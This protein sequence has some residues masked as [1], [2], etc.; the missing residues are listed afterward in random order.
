MSPNTD[1]PGDASDA[2]DYALPLDAAQPWGSCPATFEDAGWRAQISCG[3]SGGGG[4]GGTAPGTGGPPLDVVSETT[5]TGYVSRTFDLGFRTHG[6]TCFYDAASR[7]LV[8][9]QS[10]D[11]GPNLRDGCG[12]KSWRISAGAVP[13]MG[14]CDAP[15][16]LDNPCDAPDADATS[17]SSLLRQIGHD[18]RP[19]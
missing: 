17:A 11:D 2:S 13:P 6:F 19:R 16:T 10:Y 3:S 9:V 18:P 5:C 4:A 1:D 12:N 14:V 8:A 15:K 7:A